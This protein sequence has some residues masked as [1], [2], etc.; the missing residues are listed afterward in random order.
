[1]RLASSLVNRLAADRRPGFCRN[2]RLTLLKRAGWRQLVALSAV[3]SARDVRAL[4]DWLGVTPLRNPKRE[5]ALRIECRAADSLLLHSCTSGS[6]GPSNYRNQGQIAA[7][8]D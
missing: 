8:D 7:R 3:L 5:K 6:W 4:G 2:R 1:M